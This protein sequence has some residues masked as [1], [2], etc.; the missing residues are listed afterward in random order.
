MELSESARF[1]TK[2]GL[3][4]IRVIVDEFKREHVIVYKGKLANR[5]GIPVRIHSE[6]MTSEVFSSLRCDCNDQLEWAMQYFES[7]GCGVLIYLRQEGRGIGL[8]NKIRAYAL[9]DRGLDT[10]EANEHLGFPADPRTYEVAAEIITLLRIKSMWILT[11]NPTKVE[12]L[13]RCGCAITGCVPIRVEPNLVNRFY[14]ESKKKMGH[15]T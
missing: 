6:C 8:F 10:Y 12:A 13:R 7:K 14:L 3:F 11:N 5:E 4:K 15:L 2:H 9:Q 1:P